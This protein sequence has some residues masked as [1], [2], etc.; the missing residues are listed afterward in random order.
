MYSLGVQ[1]ISAL[2]AISMAFYTAHQPAMQAAYVN[3]DLKRFSAI[4]ALCQLV[5]WIVFAIGMIG[6]LFLGIPILEFFKK[7]AVVSVSITL[8]IGV[9]ELFWK[10]TMLNTSFISNTNNVPYAKSFSIAAILGALGSIALVLTTPLGPWSFILAPFVVQAIYNFW[11]WPKEAIHL[12]QMPLI[13]YTRLGCS[14]LAAMFRRKNLEN[15]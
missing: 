4:M 12:T 3:K 10:N 2:S 6:V 7:E 15:E 5:F 11:K 8:G 14:E 1:L 13:A 9:Y